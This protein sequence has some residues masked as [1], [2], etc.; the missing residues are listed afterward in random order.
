MFGCYTRRW[1]LSDVLCGKIIAFF[2]FFSWLTIFLGYSMFKDQINANALITKRANWPIE[3]YDSVRFSHFRAFYLYFLFFWGVVK[4][5]FHFDKMIRAIHHL[6]CLMMSVE[7]IIHDV[8]CRS[9]MPQWLLDMVWN[10]RRNRC[11]ESKLRKGESDSQNETE[12][13]N[14]SCLLKWKRSSCLHACI[15]M[16]RPR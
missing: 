15:H 16:H 2:L 8:G 5:H 12:V 9:V 1:D 7:S 6:T 10:E 3:W 4:Y 14:G 13:D 11:Q